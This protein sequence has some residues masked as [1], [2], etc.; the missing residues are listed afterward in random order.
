MALDVGRLQPVPLREVWAHE[1]RSFSVWLLANGG[2][3]GDALG[4][5]IELTE[6][7][8]PV[9][10]YSL[11][12]LGKD[13]SHDGPLIVENQLEGTDHDHLGKVITY[14][15]GTAAS[16]IVWL[17]SQFREEHRQALDWLNE[18]TDEGV[19]FFGVVVKA[20]RIDDSRP[21]PLFDVVASPNDWQKQVRTAA[22]A[23]AATSGKSAYYVQFWTRFLERLRRDH[24]A[25]SRARTPTSANWMNLP[26]P[27]R[28]TT[29]SVS[30][31]AGRRLRIELYIDN[32]AAF[33]GANLALFRKLEQH[34]AAMEEASGQQL[35]FEELQGK[36]AKRLA[37]YRE[38]ADVVETQRHDE[39][40]DWFFDALTRMRAAVAA[41]P[42]DMLSGLDVAL[43]A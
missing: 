18:H 22:K 3:L 4:I 34:R 5:D 30:F 32:G 6:A 40:V 33:D 43:E 41:L 20:V 13:L 15:A 25:W 14:A 29:Y 23:E 10:G 31:A 38:E 27:L 7:E 24:P 37:I 42:P 36:R 39:F 9:G 2:L 1:A 8:Y 16:T 19:R 12:L 26:S 28:G 11:D 21:A 35:V 17:A